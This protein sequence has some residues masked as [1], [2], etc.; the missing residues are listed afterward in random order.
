ML[1]AWDASLQEDTMRR[2]PLQA[3]KLLHA[4]AASARVFVIET[5]ADGGGDVEIYVDEPL[6]GSTYRGLRRCG[7]EHLLHLPSGRLM[8]GGAEDYRAPRPAITSAQNVATLPPGDYAIACYVHDE[9]EATSFDPRKLGALIGEEDFAYYQRVTWLSTGG[10]LIA[11]LFFVLCPMWGWKGALAATAGLLL[12]YFW[13]QE[14]WI[15]ARNE[16]YQ[17]IRHRMND[18]HQQVQAQSAPT[19]ILTLR[20]ETAGSGVTGG[21]VRLHEPNYTFPSAL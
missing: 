7:S 14:K 19:L 4:E 11:L 20:R 6:P 12:A 16:R 3:G 9:A 2:P 17:S 5:G 13:V 8:I 1:A 15:L 10:Y 18:Y 21:V